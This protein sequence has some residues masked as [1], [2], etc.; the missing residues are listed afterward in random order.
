MTKRLRI[1][2]LVI[3]VVV[4]VSLGE[5]AVNA[6]Q[7]YWVDSGNNMIDQ[8]CLNGLNVQRFITGPSSIAV[9]IDAQ[10][11]KIYWA[12]LR[13]FGGWDGRIQR[14]NLDGSEIEDLVIAGLAEPSGI[15]L[16]VAGG[17]GNDRTGLAAWNRRRPF[18]G[19]RILGGSR[20]RQNT[21]GELGRN[22]R[23]GSH[24]DRLGMAQG[25]R[26]RP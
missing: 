20:L 24:H 8:A 26:P 22:R 5:V 12:D 9:A 15:A 19:S 16:D 6:Q 7:M 10:A 11:G 3:A 17:T 13:W 23:R 14:A 4:V 2:A 1:P 21:A 18:R 25:D